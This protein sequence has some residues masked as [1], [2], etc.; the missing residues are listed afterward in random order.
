MGISSLTLSESSPVILSTGSANLAANSSSILE[1]L[2]SQLTLR[3]SL[4]LSL[5]NREALSLPVSPA[6][7]S[8]QTQPSLK[9]LFTNLQYLPEIFGLSSM[10]STIG[11]QYISDPSSLVSTTMSER[12]EEESKLKF[13]ESM[14]SNL[15]ALLDSPS[16]HLESNLSSNDAQT[17]SIA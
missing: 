10:K 11:I 4:T 17:T 15:S 9:G 1:I 5:I 2:S 7:E 14:P 12:K 3:L 8:R 6:P 16:I 13:L